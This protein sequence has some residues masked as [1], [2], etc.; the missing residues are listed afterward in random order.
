MENSNNEWLENE[1]WKIKKWKWRNGNAAIKNGKM[2]MRQTRM[3]EMVEMDS[4]LH[5]M[6]SDELRGRSVALGRG[7]NESVSSDDD[8]SDDDERRLRVYEQLLGILYT[9]RLW[10]LRAQSAINNQSTSLL[11]IFLHATF[12]ILLIIDTFS[13]VHSFTYFYL[14]LKYYV[15]NQHR[16]QSSQ[17]ALIQMTIYD[18]FHLEIVFLVI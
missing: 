4:S 13:H 16:W 8:A 17:A 12:T 10:K 1:K 3:T 6:E 2:A 18:I 7:R 9:H 11:R 5:E 15:N 14:Q